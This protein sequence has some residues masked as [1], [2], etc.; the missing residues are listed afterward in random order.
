MSLWVS[1][2]RGTWSAYLDKA[3]HEA[4][5]P[6]GDVGPICVGEVTLGFITMGPISS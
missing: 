5:G 6:L 1:W 4:Q 3:Q 2:A